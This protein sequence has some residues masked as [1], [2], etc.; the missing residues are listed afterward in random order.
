M[1][2]FS[3]GSSLLAPVC[4]S[5]LLVAR[6]FLLDREPG[7]EELLQLA[8]FCLTP[9]LVLTLAGAQLD[10]IGVRGLRVFQTFGLVAGLYLV[11]S[12]PQFLER[13]FRF[14]GVNE[15]YSRFHIFGLIGN[16]LFLGGV[17]GG[18]I[19]LTMGILEMFVVWAGQLDNRSR[20]VPHYSGRVVY[21][22]LVLGLLGERMATL[23]HSNVFGSCSH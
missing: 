19:V 3:A 13:F 15:C 5:V 12:Y 18:C 22:A 2:S 4:V 11:L 20:C 6:A 7:L 21:F 23:L 10:Q 9:A 8:I 14:Q 17:L 1:K 16:S